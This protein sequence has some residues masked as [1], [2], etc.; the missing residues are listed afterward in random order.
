MA[1]TQFTLMVVLGM[2]KHAILRLKHYLHSPLEKSLTER[3]N[4]Y[5]KDR[6]ESFDDYY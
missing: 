6:I 5:L 1:N 2:M 3:I 4:Q